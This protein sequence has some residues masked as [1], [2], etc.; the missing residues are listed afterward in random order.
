MHFGIATHF[1]PSKTPELEKALQGI[2]YVIVRKRP[3]DNQKNKEFSDVFAFNSNF[4]FFV[5][6]F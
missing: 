5:A 4:L 3:V 1:C 2:I 6:S